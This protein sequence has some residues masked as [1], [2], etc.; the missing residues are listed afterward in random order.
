[1]HVASPQKR[2]DLREREITWPDLAG[3]E[4]AAGDDNARRSFDDVVLSA[5]GARFAKSRVLLPGTCRNI[6]N[7]LNQIANHSHLR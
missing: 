7:Y 2:R 6:R 1:M 3:T 4:G 5:L